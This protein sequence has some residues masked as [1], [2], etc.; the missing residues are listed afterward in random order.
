AAVRASL[1]ESGLRAL[2]DIYNERIHDGRSPGPEAPARATTSQIVT[3]DGT[4]TW[5]SSESLEHARTPLR[6]HLAAEAGGRELGLPLFRIVRNGVTPTLI[7][8]LETARRLQDNASRDLK[9]VVVDV[10]RGQT[11][12]EPGLRVTPEQFEMLTAH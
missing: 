5:R 1:V 9:P 8:D 10:A 11:I 2:R 4:V 7:F 3:S 6:I 12:I